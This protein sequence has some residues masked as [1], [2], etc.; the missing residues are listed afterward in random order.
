M[1]VHSIAQGRMWAVVEQIRLL[2]S[3]IAL[4]IR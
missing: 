2:V 1:S 4:V 3:F